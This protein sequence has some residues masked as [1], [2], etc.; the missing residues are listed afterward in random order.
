MISGQGHEG[1]FLSVP[2]PACLL[3]REGAPALNSFLIRAAIA[4]SPPNDA[5]GA[6]QVFAERKLCRTIRNTSNRI[7]DS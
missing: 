7:S 4:N 1:N 3:R 6:V 5:P 2:C